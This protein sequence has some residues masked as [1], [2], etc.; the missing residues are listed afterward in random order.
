MPSGPYFIPAVVS[1]SRAQLFAARTPGHFHHRLFICLRLFF[2]VDICYISFDSTIPRFPAV[3]LSFTISYFISKTSAYPNIFTT[4]G[5]HCEDQ[6]YMDEIKTKNS[7]VVY[8]M[9][10]IHVSCM[11]WNI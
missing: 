9:H 4:T 10:A 6:L 1:S 8:L 7:Y 5:N 2:I 11:G 3:P